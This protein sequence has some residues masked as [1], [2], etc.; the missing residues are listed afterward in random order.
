MPV[1]VTSVLG[2]FTAFVFGIFVEMY[3]AQVHFGVC[4]CYTKRNCVVAGSGVDISWSLR[5]KAFSCGVFLQIRSLMYHHF[6]R[7]LVMRRMLMMF[8]CCTAGH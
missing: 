4:R 5:A 2:E 3:V 7:Y 8:D 1:T 6:V